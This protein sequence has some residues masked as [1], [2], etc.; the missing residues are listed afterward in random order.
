MQHKKLLSLA[1]SSA[2]GLTASLMVTG[3][4]VAQEDQDEN[5]EDLLEEVIVTGSRIPRADVDSASPVTVVDRT[6]MEVTGLTDIGDLLQ[7][8]PSMSGS[9]IGTTTNNGGNGGVFV[10]LRGMGVNRTLTLGEV[11][12]SSPGTHGRRDVAILFR[13]AARR[14]PTF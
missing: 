3:V 11:D 12:P 10:D 14:R 13:H 1:V 6:F 5:A 8:M 7:S 9:P 4:A 2:L